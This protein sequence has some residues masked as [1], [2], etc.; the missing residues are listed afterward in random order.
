VTCRGEKV[1]AKARATVAATARP[2]L[3]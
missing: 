2:G 3:G 1:L